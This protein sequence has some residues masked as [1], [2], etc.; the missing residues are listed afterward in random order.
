MS[1][2]YDEGTEHLKQIISSNV[3]VKKTTEQNC[4]NYNNIN[5]N[6]KFSME[7]ALTKPTF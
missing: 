2:E 6:L 4:I 1:I 3:G 5:F 7:G